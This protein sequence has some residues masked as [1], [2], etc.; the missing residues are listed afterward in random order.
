MI[1]KF[2][3]FEIAVIKIWAD[4]SIRGGHWGDG[5]FYIPEEKIILQ[6]LDNANKGKI[7]INEYEAGIMIKW[8]E[9]LR[10][11]YTMEDASAIKKLKEAVK[12]DD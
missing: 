5:D 7:E 3:D 10:G 1:V 11:V 9:S 12:Q 6:K 2:T 8:S 4:N